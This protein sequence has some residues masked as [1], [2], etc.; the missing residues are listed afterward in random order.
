M[1]EMSALEKD[2]RGEHGEL[3]FA[4]GNILSWL[5]IKQSQKLYRQQKEYQWEILVILYSVPEVW[6]IVA[7]IEK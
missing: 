3:Q 4:N 1:C 7:K 5:L 2:M 6:N